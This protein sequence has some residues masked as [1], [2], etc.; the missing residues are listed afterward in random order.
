MNL[1]SK[2]ALALVAGTT[3][4]F[5]LAPPEAT[6]F[7]GFLKRAVRGHAKKEAKRRAKREARKAVK[8][9]TGLDV[10][11]VSAVASDPKAALKA[12]ANAAVSEATGI[13]VS[14]ATA[15]PGGMVQGMLGGA[16]PAAL[17]PFVGKSKAQIQQAIQ[18]QIFQE[19]GLSR[20]S[21]P[22]SRRQAESLARSR[23]A[24]IFSQVKGLSGSGLGA[25][26]QA[27]AGGMDKD[28]LL[29]KIQAEVYQ[30]RGIDAA[31]TGF[32]KTMADKIIQQRMKK[33]M[34]N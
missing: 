4:L 34:G 12:Q 9:S 16:V 5:S 22:A 29:A 1:L 25:A 13:D 20:F 8:E 15:N 6:A 7:G 32:K 18:A 33:L 31:T 28:A 30:Q 3:L 21:P 26:A 10:D 14:G 11:K 2:R 27:L 17:R 23:A 24:D 19:K